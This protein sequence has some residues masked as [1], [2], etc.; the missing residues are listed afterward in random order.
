M[1]AHKSLSQLAREA[2]VQIDNHQLLSGDEKTIKKAW[3]M[4]VLGDASTEDE[5]KA[6][7]AAYILTDKNTS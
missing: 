1:C 3:L 2:K 6:A 7:I 5:K 4:R